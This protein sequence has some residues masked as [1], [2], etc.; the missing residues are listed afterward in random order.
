MARCY[1]YSQDMEQNAYHLSEIRFLKLE[2]LG[3]SDTPGKGFF[4]VIFDPFSRCEHMKY[5]LQIIVRITGCLLDT[6]NYIFHSY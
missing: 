4:V 3:A 1:W 6:Y 2:N 5:F